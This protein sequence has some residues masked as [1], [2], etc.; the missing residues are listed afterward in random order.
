VDTEI[1]TKLDTAEA[2]NE[3]G[4]YRES[5]E[6]YNSIL[7]NAVNLDSLTK[8]SVEAQ[9]KHLEEKILQLD[10]DAPLELTNEEVTTIKKTWSDQESA[11]EIF[12]SAKAFS[13]LGLHKEAFTEYVKLLNMEYPVHKLFPGI[14]ECFFII[15]SPSRAPAQLNKLLQKLNLEKAIESELK[16]RFANELE[17]KGNKDLALELYKEI[18]RDFPLYEG[19]G[20]KIESIE[21]IKSYDSKYGYLLDEKIVTTAQLQTALAMS[22]KTNKSVEFVLMEDM[23]VEKEKIG[24]SLAA[25]YNCPYIEYDKSMPVPVELLGKLKK[26]FLMQNNWVPL[27]WDMTEGLVEV[28]IDDPKNLEKTDNI[29]ALINAKNIKFAVG[30]QEDIKKIIDLFYEGS[31]KGGDISVKVDD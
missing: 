12:D 8:K 6:I 5:L 17:K 15:H 11:P 2:Y 4:L 29:F 3:H 27:N 16:F 28:L 9:I 19:I 18:K 13:E 31:R 25:F 10:D 22:K 26:T 30:I 21:G 14:A 20:S 23:R 1:R 24:K 7:Q